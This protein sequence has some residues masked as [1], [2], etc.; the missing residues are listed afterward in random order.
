MFTFFLRVKRS[1][2]ID[3]LL[4]FLFASVLLG[5]AFHVDFSPT[6]MKA[7]G[8]ETKATV[9]QE[10]V[11]QVQL[12]AHLSTAVKAMEVNLKIEAAALKNTNIAAVQKAVT[13]D[14]IVSRTKIV[15]ARQVEKINKIEEDSTLSQSEKSKEKDQVLIASIWSV[16]CLDNISDQCPSSK[17]ILK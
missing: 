1:L 7:F 11:K 6:L 2:T 10:L 3:N 14:K 8:F 5:T 17:D 4:I 15:Q 13:V 9:K 16:Y 12:N